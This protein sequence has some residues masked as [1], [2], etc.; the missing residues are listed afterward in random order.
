MLPVVVTSIPIVV[1]SLTEPST[2]GAS[3]DGDLRASINISA[4]GRPSVDS[5]LRQSCILVMYSVFCILVLV[6]SLRI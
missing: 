5:I 6:A 4:D 3:V 1:E 2:D